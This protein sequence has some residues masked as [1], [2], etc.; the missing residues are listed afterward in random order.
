MPAM[1]K[2]GYPT[3]FFSSSYILR[4]GNPLSPLLFVIVIEVLGR[5]V[6]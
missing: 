1:V 6:G 4:Q 2:G 3:C 5:N